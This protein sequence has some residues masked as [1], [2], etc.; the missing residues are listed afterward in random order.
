MHK[1]L[2]KVQEKIVENVKEN[3]KTFEISDRRPVM[4]AVLACAERPLTEE[5]IR[6]RTGIRASEVRKALGLLT[7]K[8][9]V[10]KT[11]DRP[12]GKVG[13]ELNPDM[14][15]VVQ[16][17]IQSKIEAV[18]SNTKSHVAECESLLKSDNGE[19]DDYD[20]LMA[21]YLREKICKMKL[22]SAVMTKRNALLRLL[23]A[24]S[25]EHAEIKK[26]PIE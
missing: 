13:Y 7:G 6:G 19:F 25:E 23:D 8:E 17:N 18:S 21:R 22:I 20:R 26:I 10:V 12:S 5:E 9:L 16:R 15:K 4:I 1:N 14:E 2:V 3:L 24:G 11:P